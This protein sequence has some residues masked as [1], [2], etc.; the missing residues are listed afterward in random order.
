MASAIS[1]SQ[2]HTEGCS[3][4]K[5]DIPSESAEKNKSIH[6]ELP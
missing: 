1:V 3:D 5:L 2:R 4:P 6:P